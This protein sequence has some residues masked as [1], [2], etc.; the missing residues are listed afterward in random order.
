MKRSLFVCALAALLALALPCLADVSGFWSYTVRDGGDAVITSYAGGETHIA[1]P[2]EL[3]G[4]P[5]TVL[6]DSVFRYNTTVEKIDIP[7]SVTSLGTRQ[8]FRGASALKRIRLSQSLTSIPENAFYDCRALTGIDIP[9]SVKTIETGAFYGCWK[10]TDVTFHEGLQSIGDQAFYNCKLNEIR[11]PDTLMSL[12]SQIF[13]GSIHGENKIY[14]ELGSSLAVFLSKNRYSF[15]DADYPQ[16][17][18]SYYGFD[19]D[20]NPTDVRLTYADETLSEVVIPD[21]VTSLGDAFHS[22]TPN[23]RNTA[24]TSVTIP[25]SVTVID[26]SV[27]RECVNLTSVELP[28][29]IV[30]MD[31]SVFSGCEKLSYVKLPKNLETLPYSCFYECASLKEVALPENL[32]QM[33]GSVFQRC[34]SLSQIDI[35][36]SVTY[37]GPYNF[38]GCVSLSEIR[39]PD[40]LETLYYQTFEGSGIYSLAIPEGI[41]KLQENLCRGCQNL[42]AVT[43]PAGLTEIGNGAL[44]DSVKTVYGYSGTVAETWAAE[45]DGCTFVDLSDPSFNPEN[46]LSLRGPRYA[47]LDKGERWNWRRAFSVVP[48]LGGEAVAVRAVSSNPSVAEVD[49]DFLVCHETGDLMLAVVIE[50]YDNRPR[51]IPVHIC[52]PVTDYTVPYGYYV[53]ESEQDMA[54]DLVQP[55]LLQPAGANPEFTF[56]YYSYDDGSYHYVTGR[57]MRFFQIPNMGS[58]Y[59]V[60]R[61]GVK[62]YF[63]V[64]TYQQYM[65]FDFEPPA[66]T[67]HVGDCVYPNTHAHLVRSFDNDY[68]VSPESYMISSSNPAV[69]SPAGGNSTGLIAVT[70]GTS[71]ITVTDF[72][73]RETKTLTFT[74]YGPRYDLVLPEDTEEIG[75]HAFEGASFES[76]FLP[77]S[78]ASIGSFAFKGNENLRRVYISNPDGIEIAPDAFYG[79]WS[80]TLNVPAGKGDA[81]LSRLESRVNTGWT[82]RVVEVGI[83]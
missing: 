51:L 70:P 52:L 26:G 9:G 54:E 37:I 28:D 60:S 64:Y 75:S 45:H 58:A 23:G 7:D 17:E 32:K 33:N 47:S 62:K 44:P 21:F 5:V 50:G 11:L 35:P 63:S 59:M 27:F 12:G 65:G 56:C 68:T 13:T 18:F 67:I 39:L 48:D 34:I 49:G 14:A 22:K 81:L 38:E 76:V 20:G 19:S 15:I 77:E 6:S 41:T 16:F 43:L 78:C 40:G 83:Q 2:E 57:S 55:Y 46:Y 53:G 42:A 73:N 10:L 8:S 82:P 71:E 69:L 66:F 4:H 29:S 30:K 3:D 24:L 79:C 1:V 25:D 36:D 74:V 80:V 31:G 72:K 61:S